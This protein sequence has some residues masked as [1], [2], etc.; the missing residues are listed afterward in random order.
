[1]NEL[2]ISKNSPFYR[3]T[4]IIELGN[5]SVQDFKPYI[6]KTLSNS[7]INVEDSRI[8]QILEFTNGHPY[9][10]Q[11]YVQQLIISYKLSS[12]HY[13]PS[14]NQML[15]QLLIVEKSFLEKNWEDIS[16][17]REDKVVL[18]HIASSVKSL[19]SAIDSKSTNIARAISS[20]KDQGILSTNESAYIIN[21]PLLKEWIIRNILK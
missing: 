1:M 8:N 4:R 13:L 21:D 20:L 2:F 16:K 12:E 7:N 19:Y 14:H 17:K 3:M 18:T 5:I 11:L 10:T 9:Y 15:D 6:H